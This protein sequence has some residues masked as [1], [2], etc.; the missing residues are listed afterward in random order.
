MRSS[1]KMPEQLSFCRRCGHSSGCHGVVKAH[2]C[3]RM[4]MVDLRNDRYFYGPCDCE[5][6]L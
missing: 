3:S 1:T 6:W 5:G 2:P 4:V